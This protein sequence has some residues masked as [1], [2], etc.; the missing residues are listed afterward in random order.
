MCEDNTLPQ[1]NVKCT[2][3]TDYGHK[4]IKNGIVQTHT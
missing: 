2:T 3:G 4:H 1:Q